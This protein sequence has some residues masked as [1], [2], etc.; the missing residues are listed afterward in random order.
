[1]HKPKV[2][3][4]YFHDFLLVLEFS[5]RL[6]GGH[7]SEYYYSR[8]SQMN[9]TLTFSESKLLAQNGIVL[10]VMTPSIQNTSKVGWDPYSTCV[11]QC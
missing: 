8:S 4:K 3:L 6:S 11:L 10:V 7:W 2:S 1:M 9:R 5:K